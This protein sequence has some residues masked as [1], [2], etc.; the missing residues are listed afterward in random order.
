MRSF[1]IQ[2]LVLHLP[3]IPITLS[4]FHMY[5]WL[6]SDLKREFTNFVSSSSSSS[7]FF[8]LFKP[9]I[10]LLEQVKGIIFPPSVSR[11]ARGVH[12]H[13]AIVFLQLHISTV[14]REVHHSKHKTTPFYSRPAGQ[15]GVYVCAHV[16]VLL[17]RLCSCVRART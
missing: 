9:A 14:D 13:Q 17:C 4:L 5:Y 10:S 12:R 7:L 8:F 16:P 3:F 2:L 15:G 6:L 1:L 11:V